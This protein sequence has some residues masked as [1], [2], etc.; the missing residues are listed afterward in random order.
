[1]KIGV[2][3]EPTLRLPVRNLKAVMLVFLKENKCEVNC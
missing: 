3:V 1:M 2:G